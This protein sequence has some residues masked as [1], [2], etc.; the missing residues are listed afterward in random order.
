MKKRIISALLAVVMAVGVC[1]TVGAS[2]TG[3]TTGAVLRWDNTQTITLALS[4][5]GGNANASCIING[6][7]NAESI[8]ATFSLRVKDSD[9]TYSTVHTWSSV[10]VTGKTLTFSN[11]TS[12]TQGKTYRLYVSATVTNTAGTAEAV[13]NYCEKTYN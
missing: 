13:S 9:G 5:S 2:A 3:E 7:S 12:A 8:S 4:F 10:S 1:G 6:K 11:S